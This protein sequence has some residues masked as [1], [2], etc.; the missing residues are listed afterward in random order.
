MG[1]KKNYDNSGVKDL[2]PETADPVATNVPAAIPCGSE[3]NNTSSPRSAESTDNDLSVECCPAPVDGI[4]ISGHNDDDERLVQ[5]SQKVLRNRLVDLSPSFDENGDPKVH[6][7]SSNQATPQSK[8]SEPH[9]CPGSA[10]PHSECPVRINSIHVSPSLASQHGSEDVVGDSLAAARQLDGCTSCNSC[11]DNSPNLDSRLTSEEI[12]RPGELSNC[13]A[14]GPSKPTDLA[15]PESRKEQAVFDGRAGAGPDQAGSDV[16]KHDQTQIAKASSEFGDSDRGGD[17]KQTDQGDSVQG[18]STKGQPPATDELKPKKRQSHPKVIFKERDWLGKS[19][20]AILDRLIALN[21]E[22][23]K[24]AQGYPV[25]EVEAGYADLLTAN[26]TCTKTPYRNIPKLIKKGFIDRVSEG[27]E[28][29]S[30]SCARYR[31]VPE[32]EVQKRRLEKG[33]SHY[34]EIGVARKAVPD[35]EDNNERGD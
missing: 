35:P 20:K 21:A 29:G 28:E 34:V 27:N 24:S 5:S 32:D 19:E 9:D 3:Q 10:R 11:V 16:L 22:Q 17:L 31:I 4:L 12:N 30:G 13:T 14:T 15:P 6:Q 2:F 8:T 25:D 1:K 26:V 23:H 7:D 18:E 33:L